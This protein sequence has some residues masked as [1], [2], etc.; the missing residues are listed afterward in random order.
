MFSTFRKKY[1]WTLASYSGTWAATR[2]WDL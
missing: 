1:R 2:S